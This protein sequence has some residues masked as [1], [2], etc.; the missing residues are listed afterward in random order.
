M[1]FRSPLLAIAA[2]PLALALTTTLLSGQA[3]PRRP[4]QVADVDGFR[5]VRDLDIAPDGAWVAYTVGLPDVARDKDE[6]DIWLSNW[7]G[8]E[9]VRLTTSPTRESQP[10]F[11]PDGKWIAFVSGRKSG[12]DDKTT[13]GQIWILS[14]QGGEARRLTTRKGGAGDVQWSPDSTRLVFVGDDPDPEEDKTGE[15]K[16]PKKPIV[17]DRYG[18][19]RDRE[20]YLVHRRSHLYLV[21]VASGRHRNAHLGRLGRLA[22]GVVAGR[23]RIA[24]ISGRGSDADRT[25]DTNVFVVDAK[26]GAEPRALTTWNGPDNQARPAWSPDGASIAYLQSSEPKLFAYSR[27]TL[28]VVPAAGGTPKLLT[29]A[30]HDRRRGAGMD[31]GRQG[32]LPDCRERPRPRAGAGAG[33]RRAAGPADDRPAGGAQPGRRPGTAASRSSRRRGRPRP[34]CTAPSPPRARRTA[35]ASCRRSRTRTTPGWPAC[36]SAR[37]RTSTSPRPT[38]PRSAPSW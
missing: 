14:R 16:P 27:N 38:A 17:I 24:F 28:A 18:F 10:R 11:S 13:G 33:G 36:S 1:R 29:D 15:D 32:A 4:M 37:S 9:H 7:A 12:D 23:A 3:R 8:T 19:K 6:G 25:N 21:N 31:A 22:A 34:R 30:E 35:S 20:G 5:D 26:A 2:T